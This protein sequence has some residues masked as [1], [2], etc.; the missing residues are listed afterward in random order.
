MEKRLQRL[1]MSGG[2]SK[3]YPRPEMAKSIVAR[4]AHASARNRGYG[5]QVQSDLW[6][7]SVFGVR[8]IP[9]CL[10]F[11]QVLGRRQ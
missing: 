2:V 7:R 10:K 8:L 9:R 6:P 3:A 4:F 5:D 1:A 11:V